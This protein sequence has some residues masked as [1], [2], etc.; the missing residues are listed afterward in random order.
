MVG[1]LH[2]FAHMMM[3]PRRFGPPVLHPNASGHPLTGTCDKFCPLSFP[4]QGSQRVPDGSHLL[5]LD[6]PLHDLASS[7]PPPI[8]WLSIYSSIS[9]AWPRPL[10]AQNWNSSYGWLVFTPVG[11]IISRLTVEEEARSCGKPVQKEDAEPVWNRPGTLGWK[12]TDGD[13]ERVGV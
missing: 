9:P 7:P 8:G 4:P 6:G 11:W 2:V 12:L 1:F 5:L 13:R 3:K 10:W